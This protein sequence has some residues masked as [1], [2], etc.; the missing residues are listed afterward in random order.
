MISIALKQYHL[1]G[2]L[3]RVILHL[4]SNT[5]LICSSN[6]FV[7]DHMLY[8]FSA[9]YYQMLYVLHVSLQNEPNRGE[10]VAN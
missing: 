4:L 10:S 5:Q 9:K 8:P 6:V 7:C 1:H 2:G 3:A